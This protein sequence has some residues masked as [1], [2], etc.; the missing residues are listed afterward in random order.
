MSSAPTSHIL[1]RASPAPHH[2]ARAAPAKVKVGVFEESLCPACIGWF[3][4]AFGPGTGAWAAY[5]SVGDIMDFDLTMWG[6]AVG[7]PPTVTAQ[8]GPVELEAMKY[9]NCAKNEYSFDQYI[10][11]VDCFDQTL[12]HTF[13]AGLPPGTVNASFSQSTLGRCASANGMDDAKL[14]SCQ[15]GTD[16]VKYLNAAKTA[17]PAHTGVPFAVVDGALR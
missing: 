8:H 13:P 1:G 2:R 17:T 7:T 9:T 10:S 6:N 14:K 4:G 11:F 5:Q 12:M 15:S 3:S 16:W